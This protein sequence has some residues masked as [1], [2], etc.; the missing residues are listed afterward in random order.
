MWS[1]ILDQSQMCIFIKY[2]NSS[3]LL[4]FLFLNFPFLWRKKTRRKSATQRRKAFKKGREETRGVRECWLPSMSIPSSTPAMELEALVLQLMNPDNIARGH[5]ENVY[6]TWKQNPD[7]LLLAQ[8]LL[9]R[10]SSKEEVR[11]MCVVLTRSLIT[12][13][14]S[15]WDN[16]SQQ[17]KHAVKTEFLLALEHEPSSVLRH[18]L[19]LLIAECGAILMAKSMYQAFDSFSAHFMYNRGVARVAPFFTIKLW[20]RP[21]GQKGILSY[22]IRWISF[23]FGLWLPAF[24]S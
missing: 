24:L 21:G 23:C 15:V 19:S 10:S 1:F 3:H 20:V 8:V 9:L 18:K 17:T 4:N 14:T 11:S 5:A 7:P 2:S 16:I 12:K 22:N 13:S 6:N